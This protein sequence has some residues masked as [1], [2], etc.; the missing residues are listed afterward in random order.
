MAFPLS[1]LKFVSSYFLRYHSLEFPHTYP[2]ASL[3]GMQKKRGVW[4]SLSMV[5]HCSYLL[6]TLSHSGNFLFHSSSV[7]T[8]ELVTSNSMSASFISFSLSL[9]SRPFCATAYWMFPPGCVTGTSNS[10]SETAPSSSQAKPAFTYASSQQVTPL[11]TC[12]PVSSMGPFQS[13]LPLA[14]SGPHTAD[15]Y[16]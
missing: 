5:G 9:G 16:W 15:M 7:T 8:Y 6:S 4:R 11:S 10:T 2:N 14:V 12:Y 1:S 13:W 3:S